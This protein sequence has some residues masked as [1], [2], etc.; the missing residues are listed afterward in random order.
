MK[1]LSRSEA[2]A[3]LKSGDGFC[4]L[5]HRRPDG[6]TLGSAAA[7]CLG[8]RALGK[9]AHILENP[10]IT[11]RYA[12]LHA[13]L[14]KPAP[15]TDDTLL[16]VDVASVSMLPEVFREY[17]DRLALRIDHHEGDACF[18]QMQLVEP[19]AAACG[20][21][22]YALL[23]LLGVALSASLAQALYTAVSTDTGCFRFAN[24][25]ENTFRVAAACA[26]TPG[27]DL[28]SLNQKYFETNRL[29]RLRMQGWMVEN[30]ELLCGGQIGICAITQETE[31]ALGV[32]ED[33]MENISAVPR[34]IEGV[35]IAAT[36]RQE[37][38]ETVKIS[39]RAV[40]GY[41]AAAICGKL[42]GGGHKGAAGASLT[43]SMEEAVKMLKAAMPD[44]G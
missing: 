17:T 6:D 35:K 32:T 13:G 12:F 26:A 33:D 15:E 1:I 40:P 3:W 24:T 2:A 19:Q 14:T 36:L 38:P 10:E 31:Q 42:G 7:L 39:V 21:I 41:D 20:E 43:A 4:I 9:T 37:T 27:A 30:V 44:L 22:I 18:T 11:P 25:T 16:C 23:E 29:A 8:L 5:T 34:S 28:F